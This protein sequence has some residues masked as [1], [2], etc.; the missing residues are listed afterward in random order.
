MMAQLSQRAT[1]GSYLPSETAEAE[2]YKLNQSAL[3]F[4]LGVQRMMFEEFL[5][6][7]DE[8]LER[9]RIETQ[10]FHGVRRENG[11]RTF[12]QGRQD[13]VPGMRPASARLL[14][15]RLRTAVQAR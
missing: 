14:A 12:R 15:S 6:L 11:E 2:A 4:M 13:D 9:T 3:E 5:F 10:L 8:M 7:S 1:P